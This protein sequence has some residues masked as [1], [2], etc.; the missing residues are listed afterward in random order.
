MV[1]FMPYLKK[2]ISFFFIINLVI[3]LPV[4][5]KEILI[6]DIEIS[7]QDEHYILQAN[8]NYFLNEETQKALEHGIGLLFKIE[9]NLFSQKKSWFNKPL[10]EKHL[11][12]MLEYHTLTNQYLLTNSKTGIRRNF[13]SLDLALYQLGRL[14]KLKIW[15]IS[16]IDNKMTYD[17]S[18]NTVVEISSLP[19]P[20]RPL[21]YLS[22]KWQIRSEEY[23]QEWRP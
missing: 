3:C 10:L 20:L 15:E 13:T 5:A 4:A 8:I 6:S 22:D 21:M 12:Y 7:K 16:S 14:N 17:I 1:S 11:K 2:Q 9:I 19:A 23:K 18:I